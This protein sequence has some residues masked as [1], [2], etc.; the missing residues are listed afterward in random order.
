MQGLRILDHCCDTEIDD[1]HTPLALWQGLESEIT[2]G[3]LR[4]LLVW[5]A[6]LPPES[7]A[8]CQQK[9]SVSAC[10]GVV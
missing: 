6:P 7:A 5:F 2:G 1:P 10:Q 8:K 4:S 9:P 3:W